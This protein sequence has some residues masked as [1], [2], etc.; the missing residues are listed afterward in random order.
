M[1]RPM[2]VKELGKSETGALAPIQ[3]N[4]PRLIPQCGSTKIVCE[5]VIR[6]LR[7][8]RRLLLLLAFA[9]AKIFI[10][11]IYKAYSNDQRYYLAGN[12][13]SRYCTSEIR[14]TLM[15]R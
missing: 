8:K 12:K 11:L 10:Y 9:L 1:Q 15:A 6:L 3:Y 5:Q 14:S 7:S 2:K 4:E 13:V